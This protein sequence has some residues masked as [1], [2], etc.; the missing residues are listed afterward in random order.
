MSELKR[1]KNCHNCEHGYR[2]SDGEYG[3]NKYFVC[4]KRGCD[5]IEIENN[6]MRPEYLEKAKVCCD[7]KVEPVETECISCGEIDLCW[8]EDV[9]SHLCMDCYFD[10]ENKLDKQA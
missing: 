5:S 1:K 3:E 8:K 6:L 4:E 2:D 7:L 9:K 10:K